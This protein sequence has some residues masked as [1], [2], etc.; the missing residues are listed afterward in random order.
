VVTSQDKSLQTLNKAGLTVLQAKVYFTLLRTGKTTIKTI[1]NSSG[2][3]R[4][5]VYRT[6]N[7]LQE[8]GLVENIISVPNAYEAIP[9]QDALEIL[10]KHKT[11]EYN[12]VKKETNKLRQELFHFEEKKP[13][14]EQPQFIMI[15]QKEALIK[16]LRNMI[17][18]TQSTMNLITTAKRFQQAMQYVFESYEKALERGVKFQVIVD[19]SE[20]NKALPKTVMALMANPNFKLKLTPTSAKVIV[21]IFDKREVLVCVFPTASLIESPAI[22]TN[23]PGLVTLCE[24]YFEKAWK[25]IPDYEPNGRVLKTVVA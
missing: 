6:I 20:N 15:P 23:H 18:N 10:M 17:E 25:Q 19:T 8:L 12:E 7:S 24:E 1:S 11:Q 2:T 16:K 21:K 14:Q 5:D 13:T 9:I 4:S 22:L 3:D